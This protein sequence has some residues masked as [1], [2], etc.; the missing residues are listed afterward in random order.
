MT[1]VYV[2]A[3]SNVEPDKHLSVAL[4]ALAS[5]Y[6]PMTLSP[7][8]KNKAVGFDGAD[9]INLVVGFN[10]EDPVADVRKQLQ[11][12]EAACDR[13]PDAPKWAP[14]TMD[15]DILLFGDLVSNQPGLVIPRPDLVK[16][17]YMLKPMADIAPDVRHPTLDRTMRELWESFQGGEHEM[18]EVLLGGEP[19]S[20]HS[21]RHRSPESGR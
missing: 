11:K 2:A 21:G 5:A 1:A 19:T 4:R 17:S 7:A 16:R 10:T 12:I 15:L 20:P 18:V 8:Y 14:R 9:F 13:P 6:G 3:G